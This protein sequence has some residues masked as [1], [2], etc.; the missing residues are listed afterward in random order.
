MPNFLLYVREWKGK[1]GK[2]DSQENKTKLE[3][4]SWTNIQPDEPPQAWER[5]SVSMSRHLDLDLHSQQRPR[6]WRASLPELLWAPLTATRC[7][8]WAQQTWGWVCFPFC[9]FL[10][11][12]LHLHTP[13]HLFSSFS[14]LIESCN[15]L[16]HFSPQ[17][18]LFLLLESSQ[19]W[20]LCWSLEG[21]GKI[22]VKTDNKNRERAGILNN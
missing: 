6:D 5:L 13:V 1:W 17:I 19:R 3:C 21:R 7:L 8:Y 12:I 20:N 2:L 11:W 22:L 16:L 10:P 15:C 4:N 9:H 14:F 18:V